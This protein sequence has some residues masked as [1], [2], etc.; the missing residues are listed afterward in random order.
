MAVSKTPVFVGALAGAGIAVAAMAGVGLHP[1]GFSDANQGRLIKAS[2]EPVLPSA[3]GAPLSFADIFEK[4]SPAV[5]SINVTSKAD[6][7]AMRRIPGFENFPFD[8][9]PRGQSP[10]GEGDDGDASQGAETIVG[11]FWLLYF[12]GRLHRHQQPCCRQCRRDKGG[13]EGWQG[14]KSHCRRPATKALTLPL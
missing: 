9:V 14:T 1:A 8:L 6:P 7:S 11:R 12:S 2:T 13:V 5:V 4:V 3:P 10:G